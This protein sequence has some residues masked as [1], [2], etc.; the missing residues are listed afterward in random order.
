MP[1]ARAKA[2]YGDFQTPASL[3]QQVCALLAR[4]RIRPAT[5]IEPTC[6]IG[7]FLC[8]ALDRFED[9][10]SVVAVDVN[11]QYV[12]Q[13]RKRLGSRP[14]GGRVSLVSASFFSTDWDAILDRSSSPWLVIG[15]PPWVT[16]AELGTFDSENLPA[17]TNVHGHAGLDAITGKSNFDISEYMLLQMFHWLHSRR[18]TLA[19][20]CKTSVARKVLLHAWKHSLNV[21]RAGLYL[22][23]A[24]TEFDASVNACL[25]VCDFGPRR[26][27]TNADVF[28]SMQSTRA[29][30]QIGFRDGQ[31]VADAEAYDGWK[32]LLNREPGTSR[33]WRSGIKHDC[34]RL[35][36]L[37]VEGGQFVNKLGETVRIEDTYLYP[38][39]KG[40]DIAGQNEPRVQRHMLVPQRSIGQDTSVIQ[41]CA[42]RTWR[43]LVTHAELL[44]GRRS[45]I[46]R[47]RPRFSIFGVGDYAFAPWKV[48]VAG[49]YKTL[50]FRVV[51]K[52][53]GKPIVLDDTCYFLPCRTRRE[54]ETLCM[55]LNSPPARAFFSAFVFWDSKRPVTV[56]LLRRLD[57][58]KLAKELG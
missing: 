30:R 16:S 41:R 39:L 31:I 23:D 11:R 37:R 13:L 32:H 57:L 15:N 14:K 36:E 50:R 43:Y 54:A 22:I 53:R 52:H 17:R 6:G 7:N 29:D 4:R 49:L 48:A 21:S 42:P 56:D 55:L 51:G 33:K 5:I 35:M 28:N 19:M 40:S 3:C 27:T 12:A 45:S 9:A 25:L 58:D 24:R 20:L 44:D 38:M 26:R 10:R 2:E 18:G 34:A 47:N 46:Y 8:A 1:K